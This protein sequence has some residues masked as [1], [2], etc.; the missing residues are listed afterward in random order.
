MIKKIVLVFLSKVYE[1]AVYIFT[2]LN[3]LSRFLALLHEVHFFV[4]GLKHLFSFINYY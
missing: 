4:L 1:K 3:K 2:E